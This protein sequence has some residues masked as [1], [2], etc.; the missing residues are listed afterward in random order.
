MSKKHNNSHRD[1]VDEAARQLSSAAVDEA[2]LL[3]GLAKTREALAAAQT[4]GGVAG[5]FQRQDWRRRMTS[6]W[7]RWVA[8]AAVLAISLGMFNWLLPDGSTSGVTFAEA[9]AK[10][11]SVRSLTYKM[12]APVDDAGVSPVFEVME[13]PS[14]KVR[15]VYPGGSVQIKHRGHPT[16]L[17][18]FPAAKRATLTTY[19]HLEFGMSTLQ[20]LTEIRDETG[21]LLGVEHRD[22]RTVSVFRAPCEDDQQLAITVWIDHETGLPV[23]AEMAQRMATEPGRPIVFSDFAYDAPLDESLFSLTPP[24]GYTVEE[25]TVD[26]ADRPEPTE[27]D[28][29][30]I[31]AVWVDL[32][33]GVFPAEFSHMAFANDMN[34]MRSRMGED[35][36]KER[37]R[38][39]LGKH[40]AGET[41]RK[42]RD[43]LPLMFGA[44]QFARECEQ[45]RYAGD[46]VEL[47]DGKTPVCWWKSPG[48]DTF[49]VVY[50]DL[51]IRDVAPSGLPDTP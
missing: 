40:F 17:H 19:T 28:L 27:A 9:L 20:R 31:L 33:D 23:R 42:G 50:G 22:G 21:E 7:R 6:H 46:G 36:A 5:E 34:R 1:V 3:D 14:G 26:V 48:A 25:R 4:K 38:Q 47:G 30:Q 16:M 24:D 45:W 44:F 51:T 2:R 18:L 43:A 15:I 29:T 12:T 41:E 8:V 37:V 11:R 13:L 49:R 35:A 10:I 39:L 32:T